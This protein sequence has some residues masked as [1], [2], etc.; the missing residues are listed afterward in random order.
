MEPAPDDY[1]ASV[2]RLRDE[3]R[4]YFVIG[5]AHVSH[6]SVDE[7]RSVI[8]RVRPDVVAVELCQQRFDALTKDSAFR[9]LDIF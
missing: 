2:T 8:E 6:T 7:V 1:P 9:D 3:H 4:E 5:T